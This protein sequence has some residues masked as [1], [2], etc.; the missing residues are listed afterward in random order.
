VIKCVVADPV[1]E[2]LD[3]KEQ[4]LIK[5]YDVINGSLCLKF[6]WL[7]KAPKMVKLQVNE[8]D[9]ETLSKREMEFNHSMNI[10]SRKAV[11][12]LNISKGRGIERIVECSQGN[13]QIGVQI[14][15][16]LD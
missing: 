12:K 8:A 6:N 9:C 11:I 5:T 7:Q 2:P 10:S 3:T 4:S 1:L 14:C 16:Q 15:S 13:K